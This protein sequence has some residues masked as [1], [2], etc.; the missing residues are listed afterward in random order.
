MS[1]LYIRDCSLNDVGIVA[2]AASINKINQLEVWWCYGV[3]LSGWTELA[4][5][6]NNRNS[7][8]C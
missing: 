5:Y 1:R 2:I 8:V 4:I 7:L 6:T 3:S